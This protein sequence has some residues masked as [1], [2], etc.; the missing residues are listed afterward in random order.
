MKKHIKVEKL[1]DKLWMDTR[2]VYGQSAGWSQVS[3]RNLHLSIIYH[4]SPKT[5]PCLLWLCGGGWLSVDVEAYLPNLIDLVRAGFAICSIE[6]AGS[7]ES[8]FPDQLIQ[9]KAAVRY[10]RENAARYNINSKKMGVIGESAGGHLASLLGTTS[11]RQEFEKGSYLNQ[12]SEVQA[13]C[14]LY[15]PTDM[16][17]VPSTETE[18]K[19]FLGMDPEKQPEIRRY[20]NPISYITERTPPFLLFHGTK[21]LI[22]PVS[23]SEQMYDALIEKNVQAVLYYVEGAEHADALFFQP[24]IMEIMIDFFKRELEGDGSME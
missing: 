4:D 11:G 20:V 8:H 2:V 21:D 14:A 13:V 9:I 22:V 5:C 24:I 16:S 7:N 17:G 3:T 1:Q 6:Y 23:C 10:L 12:T 18:W 15:A 19:L